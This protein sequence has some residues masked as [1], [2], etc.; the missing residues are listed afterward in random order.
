MTDDDELVLVPEPLGVVLIIAP[1]NFPLVTSIP[2][3][4]ALAGGS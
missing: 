1:W 3:A 4:A 2:F